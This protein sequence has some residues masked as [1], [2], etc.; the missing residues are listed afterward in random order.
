MGSWRNGSASD[1]ILAAVL[2]SVGDLAGIAVVGVDTAQDTAVDSD[3]VLD[4]DVARTAVVLAV[5]TAADQLAVVLSVEILDL[6]GTT[7]VE[8]NDLVRG[9]EGTATVDEGC[10]A[11]LLEGNGVLTD[12]GPP[13]VVQGANG[14]VRVER[15]VQWFSDLPSS[16]AVNTLSLR[17]TDNDV[18][19][20]GTGLEN[21]HGVLL[22]SLCLTLANVGWDMLVY[23]TIKRV[24]ETYCF[25]RIASCH[26]R[27][28]P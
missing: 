20:S 6:D 17:S 23:D 16:L 2:A 7:T 5:A 14:K 22:T 13:D 25:A 12:I 21:E 1:S 26:H 4:D 3:R 10:A 24:I 9:L 27:S 8:L 18:G 28:C 19:K 15:T 11:G